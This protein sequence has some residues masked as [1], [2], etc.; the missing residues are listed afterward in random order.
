MLS[1]FPEVFDQEISVITRLCLLDVKKVG[2]FE[3]L[4]A[5]LCT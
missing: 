4:G 2:R 3:E 5:E 1:R